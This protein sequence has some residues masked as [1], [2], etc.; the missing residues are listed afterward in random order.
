MVGKG[1]L[2]DCIC[3][4]FLLRARFFLMK[5]TGRLIVGVEVRVRRGAHG[6][7]QNYDKRISL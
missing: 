3:T 4:I 6:V 7:H 2:I 1:W 5:P